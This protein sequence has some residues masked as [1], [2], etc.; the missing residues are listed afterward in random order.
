MIDI[1]QLL[2]EACVPIDKRDPESLRNQ[3]AAAAMEITKL[4]QAV[5]PAVLDSIGQIRPTKLLVSMQSVG[6]LD[7]MY[8]IATHKASGTSQQV[9]Q[10]EALLIQMANAWVLMFALSRH[11]GRNGLDPMSDGALAGSRDF[12][13]RTTSRALEF[14]WVNEIIGAKIIECIA[15]SA[16]MRSAFPELNPDEF[17]GLMDWSHK[18]FGAEIPPTLDA[19]RI[20]YALGSEIASLGLTDSNDLVQLFTER[21]LASAPLRAEGDTL[22]IATVRGFATKT[23][24][25]MLELIETRSQQIAALVAKGPLFELVVQKILVEFL[26]ESDLGRPPFN[27]TLTDGTRTDVDCCWK[28]G[29]TWLLVECKAY[30]P[31]PKVDDALTKLEKESSKILDQL[32]RRGE[33]LRA[34]KTVSSADAHARLAPGESLL[35]IGV[36]VD[37][38]HSLTFSSGSYGG[39]H[40]FLVDGLVAV[41]KAIPDIDGFAAYLTFRAITLSKFVDLTDECDILIAF[42]SKSE[43]APHQLTGPDGSFTEPASSEEWRDFLLREPRVVT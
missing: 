40:I 5:G 1:N 21:S 2:D 39:V 27:I 12:L 3:L 9:K 22:R 17:R 41:L 19:G 24:L 8:W 13:A 25:A 32:A 23:Y 30:M 29:D 11:G 36:V 15:E 14:R 35:R 26:G 18:A 10:G 42:L 33:A 16:T 34:G 6:A 37:P 38:A 20:G 31:S 43:L 28:S 4:L 7:R